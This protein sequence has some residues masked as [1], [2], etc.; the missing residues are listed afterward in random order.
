[1]AVKKR[2]ENF[3]RSPR[4]TR[5][6]YLMRDHA[7]CNICGTRMATRSGDRKTHHLYYF[8]PAA[9]RKTAQCSNKSF[10]RADYIDNA[11]W[12]WVKSFLSDPNVAESGLAELIKQNQETVSPIQERLEI[13]KALL[14]DYNAQL[15]KLADLYIDGNF[16]RD[17]LMVRKKKLER[18]IS[19]VANEFAQLTERLQAS[20]F[21]PEQADLL[22]S[23]LH[24]I[25]GRLDEADNN[26]HHR[27]KVIDFLQV[28]IGLSWE[29]RKATANVI[30][31]FGEA[32][33]TI[34]HHHKG[35]IQ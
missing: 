29:D 8:C 6:Q 9:R 17:R 28:N 2:V 27:R 16:T 26:F 4:N 24:E 7:T 13:V 34:E 23:F 30:F 1:M 22:K 15:K 3:C 21:S 14:D 10:Y 20:S 18:K 35:I 12:N 32:V 5:N 19:G 31:T 25:T 33:L 11:I